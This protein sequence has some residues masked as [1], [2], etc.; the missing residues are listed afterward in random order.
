MDANAADVS[1]P[2]DTTLTRLAALKSDKKRHDYEAWR[3]QALAEA[4]A[5]RHR[6]TGTN[7]GNGRIIS[8]PY[9]SPFAKQA[10]ALLRHVF[11]NARIQGGA[12]TNETTG[13][14]SYS[15]RVDLRVHDWTETME[16]QHKD[17]PPKLLRSAG[18]ATFTK[19]MFATVTATVTANRISF[20]RTD[21][22][23]ET[24]AVFSD[25]QWLE[26]LPGQLRKLAG[27]SQRLAPDWSPGS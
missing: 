2:L 21:N 18:G 4:A 5:N 17:G 14:N 26:K 20:T 8:A 23:A 11:E 19:M 12:F 27:A 16:I 13:T 1:S 9:E 6:N 25:P 7:S 22:N 24:H 10:K 3:N 15:G